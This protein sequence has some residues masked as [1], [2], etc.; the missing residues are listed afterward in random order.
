MHTTTTIPEI[1]PA[2]VDVWLRSGEVILIDVREPDEYARE[3]IATA[4][5]VP[6]SRF[7]PG[8]VPINGA[9][10]IVTQCRSGRRSLEAAARLMSAGRS[11]VFSLKGGI[12]AWK[13]AGLPVQS[14]RA[15]ISIMRQVQLVVGAVVVGFS[16]LALTVNPWFAAVPAFMGAGLLFAGATGTCGMAAVLTTMPW[17]KALRAPTLPAPPDARSGGFPT[18]PAQPP[19]TS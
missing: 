2:T 14:A 8:A 9:G 19:A 15:P 10:R 6:L 5:L 7:D 4:R 11:E 17:N 1:D 3:R 16:A 12:E 18:A 13:A